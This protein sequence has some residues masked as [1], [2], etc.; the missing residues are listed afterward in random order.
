MTLSGLEMTLPVLLVLIIGIVLR[1]TNMI[2]R[3]GINTLKNIAVNVTL[4]AV[5]LRA[6]ATTTFTLKNILIPLA[7]F[8]VCVAAYFLGKLAAKLFKMPSPFVPF[9]TTGF[10]A[11]MLGYTFYEMLYGAE[12]V[13][14]F[15]IVDLGQALFVFTMFKLMLSHMNDAKGGM[16]AK[17]VFLEMVKSPIMIAIAAGILLG[18]TGLYKLMQRAGVSGLFDAAAQFVAAPTSV[19]ILLVIGYDLSFKGIEWGAVSKIMLVRLGVMMLMMFPVIW[20][21]ERF[22]Q[23]G[24]EVKNALYLMFFLPPPFVI[25]A[26][27]DD[28][29][30][31]GTVASVLSLYTLIS[32][33]AFFV[34]CL[35]VK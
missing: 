33:A 1:K 29:N 13:S 9:L 24:P 22:L 7:M 6:F 25:P 8:A 10:E 16:N 3:E 31:R 5:V 21:F 18:A 17:A 12:M 35:F 19:L 27:A 34:L 26:F 20:L 11:G 14:G 4:P 15:A 2:S 23:I 30:E 28:E 32:I